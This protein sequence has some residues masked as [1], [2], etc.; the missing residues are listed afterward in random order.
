MG[1]VTLRISEIPLPSA[2]EASMS[3]FEVYSAATAGIVDALI[4]AEAMRTSILLMV[5]LHKASC[6]E[7]SYSSAGLSSIARESFR[8]RLWLPYINFGLERSRADC[9]SDVAGSSAT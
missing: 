4:T 7:E 8:V 9:Q 3:L 2:R 1:A 6:C 5:E